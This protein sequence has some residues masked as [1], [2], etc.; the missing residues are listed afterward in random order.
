MKGIAINDNR[1]EVKYNEPLGWKL[2]FNFTY[3]NFAFIS[4]YEL[5]SSLSVLFIRLSCFLLDDFT[6]GGENHIVVLTAF[7]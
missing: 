3:A 1:K 6:F 2:E 7:E 4:Q 5:S